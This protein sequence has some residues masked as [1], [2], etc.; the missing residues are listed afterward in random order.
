M[1][2]VKTLELDGEALNWAAGKA[3]GLPLQV[4]PA[5]YGVPA[6]VFSEVGEGLIRYRPLVD[7]GQAASLLELFDF[8]LV[9]TSPG[10]LA[11][12]CSGEM[13][14]GCHHRAAICRAAA[15][16]M[17]GPFVEIPESLL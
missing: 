8:D 9:K 7:W 11:I 15:L 1:R 3:S 13:A 6:R 17:F 12:T 14:P 4:Q 5:Q 16:Q 10:Y 2:L